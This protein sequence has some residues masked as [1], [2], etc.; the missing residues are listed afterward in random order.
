MAKHPTVDEIK[1]AIL[2]G[3]VKAVDEQGLNTEFS[4]E[5]LLGM[6]PD[7][8]QKGRL[9][10]AL[11]ELES[12]DSLGFDPI[13]GYYHLP[14]KIYEE[15]VASEDSEANGESDS[16]GPIKVE[17]HEEVAGEIENFSTAIKSENGLR[18]NYPD[19]TEFVTETADA[20]AKSLRG[21]EGVITRKRLST[22]IDGAHKILEICDKT[23]RIGI[24][25]Y[26][27]IEFIMPFLSSF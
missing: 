24:V 13:K 17:K 1:K 2:D 10:L 12:A 20:T 25:V 22:L 6:L 15:Y 27:F 23:T 16:W 14:V 5:S 19:E 7:G 9:D 3:M 4:L 8:V 21:K 18:A 26:A 11:R